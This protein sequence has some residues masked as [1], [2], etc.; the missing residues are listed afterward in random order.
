MNRDNFHFFFL[1]FTNV[2]FSC[3][4]KQAN[5]P[6]QYVIDDENEHSCIIIGFLFYSVNMMNCNDCFQISNQSYNPEDMITF[7]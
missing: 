4:I 6:I 5:T 3:L 2:S 7:L 1:I